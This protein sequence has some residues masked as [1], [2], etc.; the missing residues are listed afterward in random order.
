MFYSTARLR[1]LVPVLFCASLLFA[2]PALANPDTSGVEAKVS[3]AEAIG[4]AKGFFP[5]PPEFTQFNSD[6]YAGEEGAVWNLRWSSE[7]PPGGSL[8]VSVSADN[9]EILNMYSYQGLYPGTK[10]SGLP[11]YS[12]EAVQ[13]IAE[14]TARRLQPERFKQTRLVPER[15]GYRPI[16]VPLTR[17]YPITY[18]YQFQRLSDGIPVAEN[19]I[20]VEVN[21]DTGRVQYFSVSWGRDL[22]LPPATGRISAERALQVF[23][24]EGLELVYVYTGP[25]DRDSGERPYLVYRLRDGG[26]LLDALTGELIDPEDNY[27]FPGGGDAGMGESEKMMARDLSPAEAAAVEETRDLLSAE[28]ARRAAEAAYSLPAGFK[29]S[30]SQLSHNWNAP[31]DKVWSLSYTGEEPEFTVNLAVDA[32][33][34]ELLRFSVYRSPDRMEYLEPPEVKMSEKQ[35]RAAAEALMR[36]LQPKKSGEVLLRNTRK[37]YG[38]WIEEGEEPPLPRSYTFEYARMV[39]GVPYPGN[40]FSVTVDSATGEITSYELKWWD[41]VFP[42]PD[43]LVARDTAN[44]AFLARSPLTLEYTRLYSRWV[45]GSKEPEYLLVYRL[46]GRTDLMI[47]ARSGQVFDRQGNP[48]VDRVEGFADIAGHPAEQDILLLVNAGVI[49]GEDDRF[50]PDDPITNAELVTL[51]VAAYADD[52]GYPPPPV[53]K[54]VPWY[55]PFIERAV[56][57]G[58]L[59]AGDRPD[60]N[61]PATRLQAARLLVNA[62]G[63][64]PL[65]KLAHLFQFQ[66]EDAGSVPAS[67]KGYAA[68]AAGLALLPLEDGRF[69][70]AGTLTRGEAAQIL[71]RVLTR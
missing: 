60:P 27:W 3:L 23:D 28:A 17:D 9:G 55:A 11:K 41:V 12:R 18:H 2:G 5:V 24:R 48:V 33:T 34:G 57:M 16:P 39:H 67:E 64:G 50:R 26:F 68:A 1:F 61:A 59:D 25:G 56:A 30:R 8:H 15:E 19:G 7:G 71:V 58:I 4:V 49:T 46:E 43:G 14:Q 36:R 6:Y 20:S 37:D 13:A 38:S 44:E 42:K 32:R 35:A 65:A 51:L 10:Y 62:Q 40:G 54:D 52:R 69:R 31:G 29:L 22:K 53:S 63:Y 70:P 21:A 45:R 66:A 47:N